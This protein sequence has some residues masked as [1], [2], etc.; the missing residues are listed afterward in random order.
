MRRSGQAIS[1]YSLSE[2]LKRIARFAPILRVRGLDDEPR[3]KIAIDVA[4][5][6]FIIVLVWTR[7]HRG[8]GNNG[9]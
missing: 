2:D 4:L 3:R 1:G 7:L 9:G 5:V 8:N 6:V